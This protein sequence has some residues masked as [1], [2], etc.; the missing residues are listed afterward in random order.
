MVNDADL[1]EMRV[2]FNFCI[3]RLVCISLYATKH[4]NISKSKS[5]EKGNLLFYH[6]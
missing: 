6:L 2:R 4:V 5:K 3:F 1:V